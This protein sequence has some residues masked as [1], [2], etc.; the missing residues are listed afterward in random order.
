MQ[1]INFSVVRGLGSI[2]ICFFLEAEL[3][4]LLL[5]RI[6]L[7]SGHCQDQGQGPV[8][9][10]LLVQARI[11]IEKY[12]TFI[13]PNLG[14]QLIFLKSKS[15]STSISFVIISLTSSTQFPLDPEIDPLLIKLILI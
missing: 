5:I 10:L 9:V 13:F 14:N 6:L 3:H 1:F 2:W 4:L 7:R 12:C 15:L 8:H 11:K